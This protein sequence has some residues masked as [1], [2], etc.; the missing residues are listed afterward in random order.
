MVS[1][2]EI[3]DPDNSIDT[4]IEGVKLDLLKAEPGVTTSLAVAVD[5]GGIRDKATTFV[6][7]FNN[8]A[9]Q[10]SK[11]RSYN[12]ETKA[13]GPML[14]DSLLL[15]LESRLR[16][17][18]SSPVEGITGNYNSLA[19]V[20][21]TTTT[22]GTLTLDTAKFDAVLA[23]DPAAVSRLFT[24]E[25]KGLAPRL[26]SYIKDRLADGGEIAAR[27]ASISVRRK[28]LTSAKAAVDTRMQLIQTRYL[29]QFNALDSLLSQMQSTSTYLTQ[30]LSKSSG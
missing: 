25:N 27:D 3:H 4:A 28:E 7:A 20:G 29:K 5:G 26:D 9:N 1:G 14:G 21:I 16:N 18:V 2:F 23:R 30:Q 6:T 12:A 10:I 13:A 17:M 19:S 24:L 22:T 8:L 15:N 11:L